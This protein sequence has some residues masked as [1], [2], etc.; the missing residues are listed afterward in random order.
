MLED[1]NGG[2]LCACRG[3][4]GGG[5]PSWDGGEGRFRVRNILLLTGLLA[6]VCA[7]PVAANLISVTPWGDVD[8]FADPEGLG[9]VIWDQTPGTLLRA[10]VLQVNGPPGG[11]TGVC[12]SAPRPAC[13]TATWLY[14]TNMFAV[15]IGNSQQGACV[16][17]GT[18]E[19]YPVHVMTI[20]YFAQG[21]TPPCCYYWVRP[22]PNVPSG[23]IE[24]ADCNFVTV[25]LTGGATIINRPEDGCPVAT[26]PSTWGRVKALYGE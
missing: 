26:E 13:F 6:A 7:S 8:L 15:N 1:A 12:F 3:F 17:Y 9:E 24:G 18:C 20:N 19:S 10:Y 4:Q 2:L 5:T 11:S 25:Y 14:D 16:A 22:D 21:T 23:E